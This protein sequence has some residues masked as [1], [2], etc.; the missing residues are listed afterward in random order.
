M[1]CD[2][3]NV[4]RLWL[5]YIEIIIVIFIFYCGEWYILFRELVISILYMYND[6][7]NW[8]FNLDLL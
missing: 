7:K 8:F 3:N 1:I 4:I 5:L 6:L 2:E